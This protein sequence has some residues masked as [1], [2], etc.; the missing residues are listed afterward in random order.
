MNEASEQYR[1]SFKF[2]VIVFTIFMAGLG[3]SNF[4]SQLKS[5][6]KTDGVHWVYSNNGLV[7]DQIPVA[8]AGDQ[9]GIEEGDL[10]RSINFQ[11]VRFPQD[12]G[13][14]IRDQGQTG[15]PMLAGSFSGFDPTRTSGRSQPLSMHSVDPIRWPAGD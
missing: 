6:I 2:A 4:L 13:R 10:L 1:K 9:A 8:S 3:L 11:T 5:N 7:A 14:I 15:K 12:V